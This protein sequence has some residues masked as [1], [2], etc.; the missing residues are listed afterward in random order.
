MQPNTKT[1]Q[2]IQRNIYLLLVALSITLATSAQETILR[3]IGTKAQQMGGGISQ[4]G[5]G[6][7][8]GMEG[9]DSLRH[10]NKLD[11]SITITF[12]YLDSSATYFLD[13]S[14]NDFTRKFPAPATN[15]YLGNLG[16]ASHSLLFSPTL[17][18][19]FDEGLHSFDVYKWKIDRV[20]FFNTTRPFSELVYQ[21]GS[22]V[23]QV[24]EVLHTQNIKPNWNF[25]FQYRLINS[26]GFFKNQK[27]NHNNYL[28]T[29]HY[30]SPKKRYGAYLILLANKLQSGENGGILDTANFLNDP[31]YKD[32]YV[33]PTKIGGSDFFSGNF[34]S[35]K[36]TTGN[37]YSD[38]TFLLRQNY[39]LGKKDSLVSDSTVIPLFF[40]RLRF[41][42]TFSISKLSYQFL[43]APRSSA[44]GLPYTPDSLWYQ[45]NYNYTLLRDTFSVQ[46]KWSD[47]TND[48]SITQFPDAKNLQQYIRVGLTVQNLSGQF[49]SG[50][51]SF[52]NSFGHAAYRNKT[53][54]QQWDI[55][56]SGKL[57]FT[58]L[59]AGDFDAHISLQKQLGKKIGSLK[60]GFENANRTPS[61]IFDSR[62]S[63]YLMPSAINFKKENNTHLFASYILPSFNLQLTGHYYLMT[64]FTYITKYYQLNQENALFNLLQ[65]A[66]NKTFTI[67]KKWKWHAD[68]YIQQRIG[69]ASVNVPLFY[70]RNRIGYEGKFG[71]KNLNIATGLE[72]R[73]TSGYYA[74]AYSP[75]LGQ[76]YYQDSI[77]IKNK[78]PDISA[79]VQFR[80]M[81]FKTFI[82]VEN[83]NTV[84]K[85]KNGGLGFTNNSMVAPGYAMP[86]LQ[87]RL[88]VYWGFVN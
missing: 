41:E 52:F 87:F 26:P 40:P 79:Y 35:S 1:N 67:K 56:A 75:I 2:L 18:S 63:F 54:N 11:D 64:N 27:T 42:H 13:T 9:T 60:L 23:E 17:T 86:G 24:I 71:L 68:V 30:Q 33:I 83:L 81:S 34:F 5:R 44:G 61:F 80:I 20:R 88:G 55:E 70:T 72:F 59:N 10:R 65:I 36:I 3:N 84:Q 7:M 78:L 82:R 16:N 12:R 73:Y 32:R 58:G 57:Y 14:I 43:D 25:L 8:G 74:D 47:I 31:I 62:S 37:K 29:S 85:M 19:G 51:K 4:I 49:A 6:R 28:F 21:L 38:F 50:K 76:F 69:N 39:D 66:A 48:F 22:R 45:H 46:D 77:K 53:K 15:V